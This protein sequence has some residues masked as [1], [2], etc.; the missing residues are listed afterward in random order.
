MSEPSINELNRFKRIVLE[1]DEYTCQCC[2]V[3]LPQGS[4]LDSSE[5]QVHHINSQENFPEQRTNPNNGITLCIN[6]H[7]DFHVWAEHIDYVTEKYF[8]EWIDLTEDRTSYWHLRVKLRDKE[9]HVCECCKGTWSQN[10]KLRIYHLTKWD[11]KDDSSAYKMRWWDRQKAYRNSLVLC[12]VCDNDF[13]NWYQ[14]FPPTPA[15]LSAFLDSGQP[16]RK[17]KRFIIK[18]LITLGTLAGSGLFLL[19]VKYGENFLKYLLS[20]YI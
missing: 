9:H 14:T 2:G 7:S 13:P 3:G 19:Y 4:L 5:L 16:E 15:E 20:A 12:T 11:W 8:W 1:R 10:K 17:T 6:C 18:L